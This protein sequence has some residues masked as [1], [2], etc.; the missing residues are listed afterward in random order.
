LLALRSYSSDDFVGVELR[1]AFPLGSN[2]YFLRFL[3]CWNRLV[4]IA[5]LGK[6]AR[7]L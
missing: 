6:I 3:S 2:R 5:F 7:S 4:R 1:F